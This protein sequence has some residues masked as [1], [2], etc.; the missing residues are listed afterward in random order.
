MLTQEEEKKSVLIDDSQFKDALISLFSF[1]DQRTHGGEGSGK[2]PSRY[3]VQHGPLALKEKSTELAE[4]QRDEKLMLSQ[5][6]SLEGNLREP[7]GAFE[8]IEGDLDLFKDDMVYVQSKD[9]TV[10]KSGILGNIEGLEQCISQ[11]KKMMGQREFL[12]KFPSKGTINQVGELSNNIR[13]IINSLMEHK[14][15]ATSTIPKK[16]SIKFLEILTHLK[17]TLGA[18]ENI[19]KSVEAKMTQINLKLEALRD[20][21]D[22]LAEEIK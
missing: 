16:Y 8:R 13:S 4:L 20:K 12:R 1:Y 5:L 14:L 17:R 19:A 2:I 9:E 21:K 22:K 7:Y 11:I 18:Y 10:A 6:G 15:S 3:K